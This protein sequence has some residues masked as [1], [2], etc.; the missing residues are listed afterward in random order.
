MPLLKNY[1]I[2]L[3]CLLLAI[4]SPVHAQELFFSVSINATNVQ[5]TERAIFSEMETSFQR[6]F[7][8]R[9]WTSDNFQTNEKIKG[10]L[11]LTIQSQ[12]TIGQFVANAQIQ[13]IRPVYGTS[14]ETLLLN[15]ADR[16][17]DFQ[18]NQGQPMDFND[19]RF[20]S[21]I[22]SL[23][24]YYAYMAIGLDYDS[25]SPLGGSEHYRKALNVVNN[26]QSSGGNGW[27]QFQSRR[28]R[29]WL[30]ENLAI[31][32]QYEPVRQGLYDYHINGLD[33]LKDEPE[34]AREVFRTV[35]TKMQEVNRVLPNAILIIAFMDAKNEEL[36][37]IFSKGQMNVR[38][39][40]YNELL[41]L[42][43]TRR[44]KYQKM[45]QN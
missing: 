43:P 33:K 40:V 3:F 11:I 16:D 34:A 4:S 27:G 35:I 41:K 38:K 39:D 25:F 20:L 1:K 2:K 32:N 15:F 19:N 10:N 8:D 28:N 12:P 7:N 5:T 22:T 37:N 9:I 24:A 45:V 29:Y 17:W 44:S 13:I 14:H 42:D 6:F 21:N 26:A 30:I 31:N 18:F 36:T 23:L